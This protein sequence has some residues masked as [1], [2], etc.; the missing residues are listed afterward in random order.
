MEA[1][2]RLRNE[3][4]NT[5]FTSIEVQEAKSDEM[6]NHLNTLIENGVIERQS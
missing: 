4:N 3:L 6:M 2:D 1:V 5:L